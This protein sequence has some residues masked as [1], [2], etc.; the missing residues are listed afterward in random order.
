MDKD[1]KKKEK[2]EKKKKSLFEVITT[3]V[4]LLIC[5]VLVLAVLVKMFQVKDKLNG[6]PKVS[7]KTVSAANVYVKEIQGETFT[8]TLE[9]FGVVSDEGDKVAVVTKTSGYVTE[10]LVEEGDYVEE[11]QTLGYVDPSTPGAK[12]MASPVNARISGKIDDISVVVGQ[13]V[14]AGSVFLIEKPQVDY[15]INVSVPEKYLNTLKLGASATLSSSILPSLDTK[16]KITEIGDK[17]NGSARTVNVKMKAEDSSSFLDGLTLTIRLDM[18][19]YENAFVVPSSAI[20][21]IG[22]INYVYIVE[23]G[24]AKQ[25]AIV[26][27]SAND[28]QTMV[29]SG[30]KRGDQ[31]V[32]KGSVG[33]GTEV[34]ILQR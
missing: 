19:R 18:E 31:V 23:D 24:K 32:V 8:K 1:K 34:N 14:G 7:Q 20:T 6:A 15:V 10:I 13:F 25:V 3:M 2:K 27:G 30:L 12:Y 33:E 22:G 16:A 11:G 21:S 26:T 4:L 9:F 5:V 28:N 29:L 17:I